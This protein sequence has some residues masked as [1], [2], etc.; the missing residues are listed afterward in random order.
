MLG[1]T[2]GDDERESGVPLSD[3]ERLLGASPDNI[4][5]YDTSELAIGLNRM[6]A[7]LPTGGRARVQLCSS[8]LPSQ[9]E[10]D[11]FYQKMLAIGCHVTRPTAT[12]IGMAPTT[13]F[14]L[15]KGSPAW[16]LIIP[17]IVPILI[18]GLVT[19]GIFKLESITKTVVTLLLVTFGGVILTAAILAKPAERVA[20][21][22]IT[23]RSR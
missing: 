18:I 16:A 6:E 19:F 10:L 23:S 12:I 7:S 8:E 2:G 20:T 11:T 1:Q 17:L 13:E 15:T 3:V 14:I 4:T 21:S 5:G 9:G 22:Y